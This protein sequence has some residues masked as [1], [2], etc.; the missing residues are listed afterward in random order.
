MKPFVVEF[1]ALVVIAF[2]PAVIQ[3][4]TIMQYD[5]NLLAPAQPSFPGVTLL[6]TGTINFDLTTGDI[7]SSDIYLSMPMC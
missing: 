6:A 3:A 1:V 5:V 7:A 2:R 4:S